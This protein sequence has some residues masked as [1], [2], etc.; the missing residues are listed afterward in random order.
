MGWQWHQLDH[1]QII[2]TL[3]QTDNHASIS[4][5]DFRQAG[6]SFWC[7]TKSVKTLKALN[8]ICTR[9]LSSKFTFAC[10]YCAGGGHPSRCQAAKTCAVMWWSHTAVTCQQ[11]NK[12]CPLYTLIFHND[13]KT[14]RLPDTFCHWREMDAIL[15]CSSTDLIYYIPLNSKK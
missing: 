14:F 15:T 1:M 8:M 13:H 5:L 12:Q 9:T 2:C 7:P 3:I 4:S 6:C 11:H 10:F